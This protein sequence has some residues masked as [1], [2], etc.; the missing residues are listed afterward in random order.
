MIFRILED[1]FAQKFQVS[2]AADQRFMQLALTLG[3]RGQGRTWPNPAVGAVVVKDGV[4]VGR[5]WTQPGGR[6]HAEPEA[7]RRAGAAARGATLYV[8]LEP[9]SHVG[10]S[11]PC[12][13]AIIAAGIARV[14][15]AIEDPNPEVAGQ[16]HARL[17]A[18]GIAVDIGLGAA[19]AAHDHAGHFR[20]IRDKRPHVILKLAVSPDDKIG[21]AGRKPMA[22]T[23]EAAQARVHLVRAQCDAVL[24]GIG[25]VRADDPLLTCRLPGMEARSP[26][27]V[28]L[29][30]AL[31]ISGTS[32]LVHSARET[33]LWVMTSDLSE[34][35]AAMKL[36]AA[37]AQVIRV[38]TTTTPPPGLELP[39]VLH[40]LAEKGITRLLVE[41]GA[42][43]ASSFVAAG[44][45]DEVWLLRGPDPVGAAGVAALDALPLTSITQSPAF[46]VRASES[47][48]KD[49]LTVYERVQ[50]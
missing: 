4:I 46:R 8:T 44:L 7:L 45:I 5:G 42:R 23:G 14:V 27:R 19:E 40:A 20:R 1:Q 31:R 47:L 38:A 13:D 30:R 21:A 32:R 41:G 3:R 43:V 22:I 36:G 16:G 15:S 9:C 17:R 49:T 12:A 39:A 11:P 48:Q 35:P 18:A 10:K 25:T 33:P 34:A 24:V 2:K 29:D 50:G 37:G 28:V 6:P 26:V